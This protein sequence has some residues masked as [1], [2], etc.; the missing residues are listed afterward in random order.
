MSSV[1]GDVKDL[2]RRELSP[3][4]KQVVDLEA[5]NFKLK[6]ENEVF[7]K[8]LLEIEAEKATIACNQLTSSLKIRMLLQPQPDQ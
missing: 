7:R 1:A 2:S 4:E 6:Q 3:V 8:A 5:E